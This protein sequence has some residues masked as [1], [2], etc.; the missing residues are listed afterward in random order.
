MN[1]N[2]SYSGLMYSFEE[3]VKDAESLPVVEKGCLPVFGFFFFF[4]C[5]GVQDIWGSFSGF[6]LLGFAWFQTPVS[7]TESRSCAFPLLHWGFSSF[8]A[9]TRT[10]NTEHPR[11]LPLYL[12]LHL[13]PTPVH[14]Q[15]PGF[16]QF[17]TLTTTPMAV[18]NASA[19]P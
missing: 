2:P 7:E 4:A 16:S 8:L 10:P 18:L 6:R 3:K 11:S 12:Y 19:A 1:A 14:L 5:M 17:P 9:P 13:Q 15:N